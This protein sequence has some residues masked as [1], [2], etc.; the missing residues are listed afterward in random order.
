V[1]NQSLTLL[2]VKDPVLAARRRLE[3]PLLAGLSARVERLVLLGWRDMNEAVNEA[4]NEARGR[5]GS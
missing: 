4:V 5:G 2:T 3:W 1:V